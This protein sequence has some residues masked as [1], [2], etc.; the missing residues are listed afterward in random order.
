MASDQPRSRKILAATGAFV[1]YTAVMTILER[2]MRATGGPGIIP[3]ELAGSGYRAEQIM[4]QWGREGRRAARVSTWLDFGYMTTY[5]TLV[6]L[7]IDRARRRRGHPRALTAVAAVAV[8]G[9]A[10]EGVSLLRVLN[11]QH[12]DSYARRARTAALIKFAA[13]AGALGYVAVDAVSP[14]R[15]LADR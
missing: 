11:R 9:D 5:G 7:L 15:G 12:V 13:L 4:T 1:G 14:L 8:A 3:F 2:R 10:V 6:A